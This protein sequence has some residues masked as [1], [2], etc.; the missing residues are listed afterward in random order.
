MKKKSRI[1]VILLVV[2]AVV[3]LFCRICNPAERMS[4]NADTVD[5]TEVLTRQI[6]ECS[7]LY[8]A[9]VEVHKLIT[10][11]DVTR[12]K[13]SV[14]SKPIDVEIPMS[15]RRIAI[16]VEAKIKAYIDFADFSAEDVVRNDGK[17]EIFLPEPK[18]V[19]TS[20]KV[21]NE[22]IKSYSRLFAPDFS[23]AELTNYSRQGRQ[24]I[25]AA[26]PKLGLV[27]SAR[28]GAANVLIPMLEQMGYKQEDITV[29]FRE[30]FSPADI[31]RMVKF[32]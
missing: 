26:I 8:T 23:D 27:D 28:E 21:R 31:L 22:D 16:P 11:A 12:Y 18:I 25:I 10:H 9:E 2:A 5:T 15:E 29:T 17:I 32:D 6:R 1:I 14:L 30:E 3:V 24:D 7:R 20:S 4:D 19:L 13:G